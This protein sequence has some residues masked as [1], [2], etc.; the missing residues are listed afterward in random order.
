MP[1]PKRKMVTAVLCARM[2]SERFPGKVMEDLYGRPVLQHIVERLLHS[3]TI[4]DIII[5]TTHRRDDDDICKL[6]VKMG[7]PYYRGNEHDVVKRMWGAVHRH[8]SGK[9]YVF[10]VMADQ[11]FLDWAALD[12]SVAIMEARGWDFILPLSFNE[13]PVY[14]AGIFPWS[15]RCFGAIIGHSTNEEREHPGMWIRRNLAKWQYGLID[16]PHWTYRP[17]RLELDTEDDLRLFRMIWDAWGQVKQ[18]PLRYVVSWLDKNPAMLEIN[19]HVREKT[20]TYT[21]FTKAE[22]RQ[23]RSDYAGRD[24]VWS[25]VAGLI[26]TIKQEEQKSDYECQKCG[27]T[28]IALKLIKRKGRREADL[29]TKCIRCGQ[30]RT[31][32]ARKS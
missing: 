18:I 8:G 20:G 6:A 9:P 27:G 7:L 23:W 29:G 15:Y 26:G 16:L 4:A 30:K 14:G 28:L 25:D 1:K 12:E 22:I 19:S 13:D 17:Y 5:A 21:S 2:S 31:F 24:I 10:R 11:P 3:E 32:Y